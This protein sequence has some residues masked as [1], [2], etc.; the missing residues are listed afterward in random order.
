[1]K[2][3]IVIGS[4]NLPQLVRLQLTLIRDHC[5]EVPVLVCDDNSSGNGLEPESGS[6][7]AELFD[8]CKR[9]GA[10]LW[11]NPDRLGHVGG[12]LVSYYVGLQWGKATDLDVICKL[13]QRMLIDLPRWLQDSSAG[14]LASGHATGCQSCFEGPHR[15]PLRTEAILFDVSQWY[16]ADVLARLWPRPIKTIAAE[17]IVWEA[18]HLIE[19]DYWRWPLFQERRTVK[20]KGTIW[21]CS[22]TRADYEKIAKRY[23]ITL[24]EK[25]TVRGWQ[26]QGNYC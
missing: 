24:D 18:M 6:K 12:D 2:T 16:R 5:G 3:G 15:L 21:H 23:G 17:A 4:Y 25:F 26:T 22:H 8:L 9:S 10:I 19:S 1:M 20:D 14:L 13:S 11:S 7:F